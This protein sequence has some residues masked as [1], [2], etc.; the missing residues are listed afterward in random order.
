M[1]DEE[2]LKSHRHEW[3]CQEANAGHRTTINALDA[4]AAGYRAGLARARMWHPLTEDPAT[5]P[6]CEERVLF[7]VVTGFVI[8]GER[9]DMP[10]GAVILD[11]DD[12]ARHHLG[13]SLTHWL[14]LPAPPEEYGINAEQEYSARHR[15]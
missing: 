4:Y 7:R 10:T 14:P 5:W 11:G 15:F 9:V 3:V 1:K 2:A 6:A 13:D 8:I 12:D